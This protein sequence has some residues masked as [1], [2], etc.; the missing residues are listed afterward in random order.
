MLSIAAVA[1]GVT[2]L[3]LSGRGHEGQ[4]WM[5]DETEMGEFIPNQNV[6]V[7]TTQAFAKKDTLYANF[8][9]NFKYHFQTIGEATF[10]DG[11]CLLLISEPPPY[12][13]ADTINQIFSQFTHSVE[14]KKHTVGYD[15]K[16]SDL[17]VLLG[18][19]TRE[20]LDRLEKNLST[21]LYLSDYKPYVTPLPVKHGRTYFVDDNID[22]QITLYEFNDWFMEKDEKFVQLPDTT[23]AVTV[24]KMFSDTLTG[25]FFSKVPGFVAWAIAKNH[26]LSEQLNHIRQFTLDA[27]LVLG[28]LA[29]SSTLVV[30][31]RER[32]APLY[33]L[34][35]LNVESVLLL[36]AVTEKELSQSLDVND[37]MAG[38]MKSGRDW[39]P[40]YLSKELENTEFGHLLTITDVLLKDWSEN[41]TIQEAFY[42]YPSPPRF[43]FD[44][45]LFKKLGLSELVYNWNTWNAMYAIDMDEGFTIYTLNRTGS[46]PVS[47]FNSPER[48]VSVGYRYENQAYN[49]FATLG[50]TDLARVVQYTALYQLFM[51]NGITYSGYLGNAFPK[52]KPYLLYSPTKNL[53]DFFKKM[54]E[55]QID[56]MADTIAAK[57]YADYQ[58]GQV[59]KQLSRYEN[60][61]NFKYTDEQRADIYK[62]VSK[63]ERNALR[64]EIAGVKS[65]L[66]GLN[67]ADYKKLARY[68][69][70]PRG[71]Q[72]A[73]LANYTLVMQARRLT[74]LL[75]RIGK[76]NLSIVGLDL[77]SVKDFYVNS[78]AGSSA[79]YLKTPS[80]IV[81]YNDMLTTGGHNLSSGITRV[82][83][84][85]G[86]KRGGGGYQSY[87]QAQATP[88]RPSGGTPSAGTTPKPSGGK[89]ST[90]SKGGSRP[91]SSGSK[92]ASGKSAPAQNIRPRAEVISTAARSQR[93]F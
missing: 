43:P 10:D 1:L 20:N 75:R 38:K 77:S 68:L 73:G 62:K 60:Q 74:Q 63:D 16:I 92:P 37:F 58:K 46:L 3:M 44:R 32:Q 27:D 8:R 83:S 53:M 86:Y 21:A 45:P 29:D 82:H 30:I 49:Y 9:S 24:E 79:R 28:A 70:Y 80:V 55:A 6:D 69:S 87:P 76:N 31:G 64:A 33:E 4:A 11:S 66:N 71:M 42:R 39:C 23:H 15:G 72:Q 67:D 41:G 47:Y 7:A 25:V 91:T 57:I 12:F 14:T 2:L 85:T 18:N 51:D 40:T 89:P 5:G 59:T 34:P 52:N 78:L 56:W 54:T 36:A 65:L 90:S 35:P 50:N 19:V 84:L 26:D 81:T 61:Y 22:Y 17:L 88:S 48:S 93:G 13:N